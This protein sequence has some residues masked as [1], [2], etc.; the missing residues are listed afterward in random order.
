MAIVHQAAVAQS[1]CSSS[2]CVNGTCTDSTT[3]PNNIPLDAYRCTCAPGFANG[4]CEYVYVAEY[5]AQCTVSSSVSDSLET[6][7]RVLSPNCDLDVDECIS[8]PCE[9]GA[10]CTE[11][12]TDSK[13]PLDAFRCTCVDGFANGVCEYDYI[14]E[15]EAQ[16][17]VTTGGTCDVDV[18]ECTSSP[19][20]NNATCT[21]STN[22]QAVSY[23]AYKCRCMPG[24]AN[25]V[26]ADGFIIDYTAQCTMMEGGNCDLDVDECAS[27]PCENGAKCT[28][29]STDSKIPLDAFRCTCVDGFA[30][31][32]CEYD[33]ITE[34]E[35]QCNV[36]TG[37]TCDVD[38]DECTSSPCQNNATCTD[39]TNEQAV[40]YDAYKCRCMP[41]F[42]NGV[43]ADGFIID[44]TAQ[45]TMMEGGNCDLDV[46]EC[47]SSPCQNG[48]CTESSTDSKI[49]LDAYRCVDC[50]NLKDPKTQLDENQCI[51]LKK[52]FTDCLGVR[53][54]SSEPAECDDYRIK[55]SSSCTKCF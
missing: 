18:D 37:G 30:N 43:C 14:T 32:V 54:C 47:A 42:A 48:N 22:E 16:C 19:C 11:S 39:S 53:Q 24:F 4:V 34:Y 25:G 13:I 29:S 51:D 10:K 28:E 36:T 12:S 27:S 44:Y 45:C 52:C 33:Y 31:G 8:S 49:P 26:C 21:D 6:D 1:E 7:W 50:E 41:G 15:Y 55:W 35:A 5:E 46:D 2:P 17:N 3:D 20:Q 9:N 23:D 38:V 40:S